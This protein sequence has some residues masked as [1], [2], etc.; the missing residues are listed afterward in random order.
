ML[1]RFKESKRT[2][3]SDL[4]NE[5]PILPKKKLILFFTTSAAV[6]I[7]TSLFFFND[8]YLTF[9]NNYGIFLEKVFGTVDSTKSIVLMLILVTASLGALIGGW[10]GDRIGQ[11]KTYKGIL[12]MRIII[13]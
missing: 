10:L 1:I 6:P 7:L 13:L 5:L 2:Y 9:T 8:A 12:V 4:T 11:L 3:A